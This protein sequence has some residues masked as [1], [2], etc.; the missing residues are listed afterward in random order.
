MIIMRIRRRLL[1]LMYLDTA[2]SISDILTYSVLTAVP[3]DGYHC[4]PHFPVKDT[5]HREAKEFGQH[6]KL[7]CPDPRRS[8]ARIQAPNCRHL[9]YSVVTC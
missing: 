8:D 5:E 2:L 9:P 4:Y 7:D 6:H 1:M 3:R